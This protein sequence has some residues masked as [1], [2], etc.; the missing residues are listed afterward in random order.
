MSRIGWSLLGL[1]CV[2][3][4][5]LLRPLDTNGF[6][7]HP[8]PAADY[9]EALRLVDALRAADG[10]EISPECRTELLAHGARTSRVVL[11]LH[12]LTNCPAQFDSLGRLAFARGA[13][14]L[15]PRL[16]HHGR[17]DRMTEDLARTDARELCD[18]TDRVL[19]AACGLGDSV[20]VV[21]L[22][23]GGTL[24]AWAA[25]ERRE[26]DRAVLIAPLLGVARARGA[27][28]APSVRLMHWLPN[29]FV[30]WDAQRREHLGGPRHVYPRFSTRAVAA[31]SPWTT[32]SMRGSSARGARIRPARSRCMSFPPRSG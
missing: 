23:V 5:L 2:V 18:F 28:R 25:V 9:D 24:A 6:A 12:G 17:A 7:S 26:V 4:L 27:W 22:S 32:R 8:R 1:S 20:T 31:T 15:I 13:N 14:V 10:P 11:L 16:P 3:A 21:G 19:D 29:V 30:W